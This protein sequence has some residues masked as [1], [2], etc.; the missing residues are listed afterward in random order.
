V[1]HTQPYT[2]KPVSE[3]INSTLK[4][5][6]V[7]GVILIVVPILGLV[8]TWI[9][10]RIYK[11]GHQETL[12]KARVVADQIVLTRQWVTDAMGGVY[13]N[14]HSPGAQGVTW[15]TDKK[16]IT[17]SAIYGLFTPSMVTQKLSQYSFEKKSYQFR[18]S[19]LQPLNPANRPNNFEGIALLKF[20]T[21]GK[22]EYF[23]YTDTHFDYMIPLYNTK[24]CTKCHTRE[25][26]HKTSIIGGLRVTIPYKNI[27]DTFLKNT[28]FL[29]GAGICI[30][31]VTILV[32]LFFINTLILKP[33]N[34]LEE[35]SRQLTSGDLSARV[36]LQTNDELER[37]GNTFNQMAA[38]LMHNR[39]NLEEQISR[40]TKDLARAN[41]ELLKLDKLKSD[42]LANMSHELRTPLTAVKGSIDYLDRTLENPENLEFLHII[43]KNISRLTRLIS[44]L[45][46]FTRLEAGTIE[47]EFASE[48]LS[49]LVHD[50][51]DILSP[52]AIAKK[53]EIVTDIQPEIF[54]VI[55]F[56]RM[57]QVMVNLVDN[58][59]KFSPEQSPVLVQLAVHKN[60][61]TLSVSDQGPG[62]PK[63]HL[64][65]IFKK[66]YTAAGDAH[67][68]NQGA[69]MGL[70]IS[71]AIVTAH[72]GTIGVESEEGNG[73]R[74]F[75]RLPVP[76]K[77]I[78]GSSKQN[79]SDY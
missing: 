32:L 47:W 6:F 72:G 65:T 33:L 54:A 30:T 25:V 44:N 67:L 74:F 51:V 48:D 9:G 52:I 79:H 56:E 26:K 11:Q 53:V 71:R 46:D 69:G 58:A 77:E 8:F 21:E 76:E 40:A 35:R 16:I 61:I 55:D 68:K 29:T 50:V 64:E 12:E 41:H 17:P 15:A 14:V 36:S 57:E 59:I 5:K 60:V 66:F 37:L 70:A 3:K 78:N 62:I 19:S 34:E 22:K 23:Q 39:D 45:F 4:K 1:Q 7:L 73:S 43:E 13:V 20:K 24:G 38:S 75:V 27:R 10:F 42:F 49:Q 63:E 28:W 2:T 18:L 31:V